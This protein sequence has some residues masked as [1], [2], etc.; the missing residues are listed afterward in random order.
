MR[1]LNVRT[2]LC[3]GVLTTVACFTPFPHFRNMGQATILAS[4]LEPYGG[5]SAPSKAGIDICN[6]GPALQ[7]SS[8]L[9]VIAAATSGTGQV[10][11][12]EVLADG[13]KAAEG[14]STPLDVPISLGDGDHS[15]TIIATDSTGAEIKSPAFS[16][17]VQEKE[18]GNCSEP[19]SPGVH[20][21]AP[22]PNGCNT[23]PWVPIQAAGKGK[24]GTVDRMELWINGTKIANFPGGKI[25]TSL[26]QVFGTV[27]VDEVDSKGNTE[28]TSFT[29]NGPC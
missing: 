12:M 9:Q 11:S 1:I 8:P 29:F 26:I 14:T 24:S 17:S 18:S 21:C 4:G 15:L 13:K 22:E 19:G 23:E 5:C 10:V 27:K 6:P 2:L 16:V 28:S 20:V 3:A 25:N 7:T